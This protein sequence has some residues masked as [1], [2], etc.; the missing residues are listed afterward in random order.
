MESLIPYLVLLL[1]AIVLWALWL[2]KQN[3]DLHRHNAD[4][5][6]N[7]AE[8]VRRQVDN[9]RD[10]EIEGI[11]QQQAEI[12]SR[13]ASAQLATWKIDAEATIR[14]DAIMRS[15]AVTTGK[16]TEQLVPYLPG[17]NYNPKD[18]RFLGSPTDFV[19]FDGLYEGALRKIVFVE[20]KSRGSRLSTSERR[21]RDAVK[22]RK[23]EWNESWVA[24]DMAGSRAASGD[25]ETRRGPDD[26]GVHMFDAAGIC[27]SCEV[28][29]RIH[30]RKRDE[31]DMTVL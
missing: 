15:Q 31:P 10:Q 12:A 9:W 27:Q 16:V 6:Q 22:A 18:V 24:A 23:V 14:Q 26:G 4:L 3:A 21:V 2:Q 30:R 13:E 19:I 20:V 11:R 17:F 5:Y 8:H 1:V 29:G 28:Q 25:A 7:L